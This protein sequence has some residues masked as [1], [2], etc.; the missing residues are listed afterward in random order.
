MRKED[1]IMTYGEDDLS[2]NTQNKADLTNGNLANKN[3]GDITDAIRGQIDNYKKDEKHTPEEE[4]QNNIAKYILRLLEKKIAQEPQKARQV[5]NPRYFRSE[6]PM[7]FFR[8]EGKKEGIFDVIAVTLENDDKLKFDR[9]PA[10]KA[11]LDRMMKNM[12]TYPQEERKGG[13]D[14]R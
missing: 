3:I 14:D 1:L 5:L 9:F 10:G 13:K 11:A 12:A 6:N 2:K 7:F 4:K 8:T